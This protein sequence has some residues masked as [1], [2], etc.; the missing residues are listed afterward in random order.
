MESTISAG[1]IGPKNPEQM[2]IKDLEF[3][4]L[5]ASKQKMGVKSYQMDTDRVQQKIFDAIY[6]FIRSKDVYLDFEVDIDRG[7]IIVKVINKMTEDVIREIS[8][9]TILYA[10]KSM[11]GMAGTLFDR[12]V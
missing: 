2:A 1:P 10:D 3:S 12:K 6:Q 4:I 8:L 9:S 11:K 5:K 7:R